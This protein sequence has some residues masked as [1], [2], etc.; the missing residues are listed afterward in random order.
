MILDLGATSGISKKI[1]F[2]NG[3][4]NKAITGGWE[5]YK[6]QNSNATY[7]DSCYNIGETLFVRGQYDK[8]STIIGT[9]KPIDLTNKTTI[10]FNVINLDNDGLLLPQ[11]PWKVGVASAEGV[12]NFSSK[13]AACTNSDITAGKSAAAGLY[14]L[15]VSELTGEYFVF[16]YATYRNDTMNNTKHVSEFEVDKIL[17]E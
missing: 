7:P 1:L 12:S 14:S 17:I 2:L 11:K 5:L 8:D 13:F 16:I 3:K 10:S 9:V 4:Q 6:P 15:D